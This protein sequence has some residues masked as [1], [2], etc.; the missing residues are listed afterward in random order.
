[1]A[2]EKLNLVKGDVFKA[3]HVA[4]IEEGIAQN[5]EKLVE[6]SEEIAELKGESGTG[7]EV[8]TVTQK[9]TIVEL[10]CSAGTK[11]SVQGSTTDNVALYHSGLNRIP[12]LKN[13][14]KQNGV[15]ITPNS[16]GTVTISGKPT[17]SLWA[18][19]LIESDEFYLPAGSYVVKLFG[20][21]DACTGMIL[22]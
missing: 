5:D 16:N 14:I 11:L 20:F 6:L 1:M 19:V 8:T 4:H 2:Y 9:G 12:N 15:T 18:N 13:E 22:R 17:S 21:T 10:D 3:E 7:S